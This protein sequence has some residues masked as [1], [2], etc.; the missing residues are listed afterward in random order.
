M[1]IV[2]FTATHIEKAAYIAKQNY[3]K[4]RRHVPALPHVEAV[5]DLTQFAKNGLGVS[6]LEGDVVLGF[7]C[8]CNPWD[9]AFGISGLRHVYSPM[10]ANGTVVENRA[11]I[12]ARLYEAAGE[13]WAQIGAVSHGI[14]LYA[15]DAEGQT[16]FFRYGFGMRTIDAIRGM[17][18]IDATSC[19]AYTFSELAPENVAEVLPFENM[20]D[21][22]YI[23]SP[24]FMYR[25][26]SSE[27]EFLKSY[28]Q[29]Q[30][31]YSDIPEADRLQ[32]SDTPI[33][34]ALF[35]FQSV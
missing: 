10:G 13:K 35:E 9:G 11:K 1:R 20:L 4:E 33:L 17:D 31:V 2:N 12:Y 32:T 34:Q 23:K 19:E 21:G 24:F 27:A 30:S 25:E 28:R 15:H 22:G 29:F 7:L 14:C 3:E 18:G 26:Q 16:Q 5:L 6:A 8:V